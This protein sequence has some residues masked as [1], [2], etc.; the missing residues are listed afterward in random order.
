MLA[1]EI[2][3]TETKERIESLSKDTGNIENQMQVLEWKNTISKNETLNRM[4]STTKSKGQRKE[5]VN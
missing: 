5:S 1:Q 4:D 2:M 3:N